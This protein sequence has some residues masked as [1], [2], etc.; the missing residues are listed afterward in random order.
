MDNYI[1]NKIMIESF[2]DDMDVLTVASI[3]SYKAAIV[4]HYDLNQE[5]V[6]QIVIETSYEDLVVGEYD[7]L[8]VLERAKKFAGC[9]DRFYSYKELLNT[10]NIG[11]SELDKDI[12]KSIFCIAFLNDINNMLVD[13]L[14]KKDYESLSKELKD[15]HIYLIDLL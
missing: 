5:A 11:M 9:K 3:D 14:F 13:E 7:L 4:L 12:N 1:K 15:F 10:K 8:K 6:E 2:E